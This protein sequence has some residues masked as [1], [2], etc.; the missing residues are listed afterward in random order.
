MGNDIHT[1]DEILVRASNRVPIEKKLEMGQDVTIE[2]KGSV[3]KEEVTD[4]QDGTVN[5]CY[6]VKGL[7]AK[8]L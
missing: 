8:V 7:T 3:V 5:V 6:I 1:I 4:N 2:I